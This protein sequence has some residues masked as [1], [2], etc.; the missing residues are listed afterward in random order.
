MDISYLERDQLEF[1]DEYIDYVNNGNLLVVTNYL[2]EVEVE[3]IKSYLS[4]VGRSSIPNYKKIEYGA[5]NFHRINNDDERAYVKG[6]FQQFV[7]YPWNQ[8]YFNFFQKFK[9]AYAF[10]NHLSKVDHDFGFKDYEK[11]CARL[12][13]QFYP[14]G[15][16]YLAKHKDPVDFHQIVVPILVM[17]EF[18]KDYEEGGLYI[19]KDNK[20]IYIDNL[21]KPGDIVYFRADI[22]HGVDVIDPSIEDDWLSYNGRWMG[23]LAMNKFHDVGDIPDS[24]EV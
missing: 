19:E 20:K 10:K 3:K 22:T 6:V 4:T 8:D 7:F 2:S 11:C 24:V 18:G 12:A 16:G 17:S 9:D 23:L 5:L 15:I 1:K 21:C 13:F 14:G